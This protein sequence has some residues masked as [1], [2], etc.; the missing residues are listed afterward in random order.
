MEIQSSD[1]TEVDSAQGVASVKR[2]PSAKAAGRIARG[3]RDLDRG[4]AVVVDVHEN[5]SAVSGGDPESIADRMES[6]AAKSGLLNRDG[7]LVILLS[8]GQDSVCLLELVRRIIGSEQVF[9]LHLNYGLREEADSDEQFCRELCTDLGVE[10]KVCKPFLARI[11]NTQAWAR[12]ERYRAAR[13]LASTLA[14]KHGESAI[15]TGHT[16]SDQVE[17]ILYRLA[18]SPG[19]QALLGMQELEGD[20]IRPLL[21]FTRDETRSY[22]EERGLHWRDDRSNDDPIYAR[23]RIRNSLVPELREVHP[24][25]EDNLL[26]TAELLRDEAEVLAIYVDEVIEELGHPPHLSVLRELPD[27][28]ARLVLQELVD[29]AVGRGRISI[30]RNQAELL[31]LG[32]SGGTA[33]LDIGSGVRAIVEYDR[34][35]FERLAESSSVTGDRVE[36]L[37]SNT[38]HIDHL[39][40]RNDWVELSLE[41]DS[42]FCGYTLRATTGQQLEIDRTGDTATLDLD[43]LQLPLRIRRWRHGDRMRPLGLDGTRSLHDLF[44]DR[45][46][47]RR[48]RAEL[49]IVLTA[50]EEIVWVPGVA[51]ADRFRITDETDQRLRIELIKPS[52]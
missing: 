7:A 29:R 24:A 46:I 14:D 2:T 35:R 20:L 10:L 51:V 31:R 3:R 21:R 28:V 17:T 23:N 30:R 32:A 4:P 49:P 1:V 44:I 41:G 50:A 52:K 18:S 11:G 25:A 45:K 8:G 33:Y 38:D 16:A 26:V 15:A 37:S 19:R 40:A 9:A 12:E 39:S 6:S 47:P 42:I 43:R 22:C 13:E 34:L 5:P 36:V 27:P 48:L